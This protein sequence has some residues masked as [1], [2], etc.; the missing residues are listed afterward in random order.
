MRVANAHAVYVPGFLK[1]VQN[2]L[3]REPVAQIAKFCGLKTEGGSLSSY[4]RSIYQT[5]THP[6]IFSVN[7]AMSVFIAVKVFFFSHTAVFSDRANEGS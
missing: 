6:A 4:P 5:F 2:D 1:L 7:I 3:M